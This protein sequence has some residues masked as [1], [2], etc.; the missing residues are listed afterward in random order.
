MGFFDIF[1]KKTPPPSEAPIPE[2]EAPALAED[3]SDTSPTTDIP[4]A[5]NIVSSAA[6][7][8]E[9]K[10]KKRDPLFVDAVDAA[11]ESEMASS[12]INTQEQVPI[13][14]PSMQESAALAQYKLPDIR[15]LRPS[16]P[17]P[18][19]NVTFCA[20][21]Q[22]LLNDALDSFDLPNKIV[23]VRQGP[24][25]TQFETELV[26]G[27]RLN[28][29]TRERDNL[30]CAIGHEILQI[31]PVLGVRSTVSFE[32]EN[33]RFMP[34]PLRKL[35]E[36]DSLQQNPSSLAFAVGEDMTGS[37][38]ICDLAKCSHLLIGG[39]TGTGKTV[40]LDT[41]LLSILFRARPTDVRF[42]FID[43]SSATLD[44]Q[45]P[46]LLVPPVTNPTRAKGLLYWAEYEMQNRYTLLA[47]S[48]KRELKSY[49]D[50]QWEQFSPELA[51]IV[52]MIDGLEQLFASRDKEALKGTQ[53]VLLNLL[54]S[55]QAVG[56][57]LV[58]TA[59][60][61]SVRSIPQAIKAAFPSKICFA[62]AS[63]EQSRA[64][65]DFNGAEQLA[66]TGD[67]LYRPQFASR[68]TRVQGC[69]VSPEEVQMTMNYINQAL[70]STPPPVG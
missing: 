68:P 64:F 7:P 44:Y 40:C 56:I 28:T 45:I 16:L 51:H 21:M 55:G 34:V 19:E 41:I 23:R 15:I 14:E 48:R 1:R 33:P 24:R 67:M 59:Q 20:A 25:F 66:G 65:L 10:R 3:V 8:Q 49:N 47:G 38:V 22:V 42:V 2:P 6:A 36:A 63:S 31:Q 18:Q 5:A 12:V 32:I 60:A 46:H 61:L 29:L 58:A 26:P 70:D 53:S 39:A 30:S 4:A 62:T 17:T 52:V 69:T 13:N 43:L 37:D 54:R 11:V 27:Q 57:H 35:L 50:L 9:Q